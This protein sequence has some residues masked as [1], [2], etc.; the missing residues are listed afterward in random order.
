MKREKVISIVKNYIDGLPTTK[1]KPNE[2]YIPA[3]GKVIDSNDIASLMEAVLDMHF[4]EG[5][6]AKQFEREIQF[7]FKNLIRHVILCNSGSSANLLAVT[8]ITD[9]VF[10]EHSAHP[11]DEIITVAAGFPTTLNP[12][13]QNKLIPVFVDV[14]PVTFTPD[15]EVIEHAVTPKTKGIVL[16]HPLGN[17]FEAEAIRDICDEYGL[18]MVEDGCDS[19]GGT[20]NGIPVGTFGDISTVSFYPA[21]QITAGEAGA[22]FTNEPMTKKVIE[23]FRDWGRDCWCETGKDNTC[24]KRF[25]WNF[26]DL[27]EGYDHKYVYS[28]IGYNL[29]TT[30][31]QASLLV[32]QLNKLDG[33]VEKRRYNW[34]RLHDGLSKYSKYLTMPKA[35]VGSKPSW[36]GFSMGVRETAPFKRHDITMFL[37]LNKI[38]TRLMFGGNLLRQP[39]YKNISHRIFQELFNTNTIMRDSFWIGVYPGITDE[40]IDYTLSTFDKFM[41]QYKV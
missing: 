24:G 36:F 20:L 2:T 15:P 32:S 21:H 3:S 13:I 27:P 26:P 16:A 31:L 34:K 14:D 6:W 19:L 40:M 37:E 9:P 25:A 11:G 4:T 1:F 23:S 22:I 30:D 33:F 41:K 7:K 28:R 38:G 29:K 39:A 10:G 18:W 35:T 8:A 17:P 5:R 12:I